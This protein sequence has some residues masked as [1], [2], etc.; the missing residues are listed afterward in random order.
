MTDDFGL[1]DSSTE[2]PTIEDSGSS[3]GRGIPSLPMSRPQAAILG[4]VVVAA[5][6]FLIYRSR[7]GDD[8][9]IEVS[10]AVDDAEQDDDDDSIEVV[11]DPNDPMAADEAIVDEFQRRGMIAAG[12]DE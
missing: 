11:H 5:I 2:T 6:V 10:S 7:A 1:D 12:D 8:S 9:P 3:G 4:L